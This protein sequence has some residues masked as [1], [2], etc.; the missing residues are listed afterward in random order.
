MAKDIKGVFQLFL[1]VKDNKKYKYNSNSD[2]ADIFLSDGSIAKELDENRKI[3]QKINNFE[4]LIENV[5][6][7][8]INKHD[9]QDFFVV[10]KDNERNEY[11]VFLIWSSDRAAE[12]A[13]LQGINTFNHYVK[14]ILKKTEHSKGKKMH[15]EINGG[16]EIVVFPAE[17][18]GQKN[19]DQQSIKDTYESIKW[20]KISKIEERIGKIEYT[21]I[22]IIALLSLFFLVQAFITKKYSWLSYFGGIAIPIIYEIIKRKISAKRQ[23]KFSFNSLINTGKRSKLS[24]YS[25]EKGDIE[26]PKLIRRDKNV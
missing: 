5:N 2:L 7:F 8:Y 10:G 24:D 16:E 1:Q 21:T 12:D 19:Y 20:L 3:L 17:N 18:Y 11:T 15:M 25:E 6:L 13:I 9:T 14:I 22:C 26:D 23:I 4:L